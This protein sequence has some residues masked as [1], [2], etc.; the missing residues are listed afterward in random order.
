MRFTEGVWNLREGVT[1]RSAV[2]ANQV[3]SSL[4]N[5]TASSIPA[6]PGADPFVQVVW[7]NQHISGRGDSLNKSLIRVKVSSPAESIFLVEATHWIGKPALNPPRVQLFPAGRPKGE[8]KIEVSTETATV[9]S[10]GGSSKAVLN[11]RP[12]SFAVDFKDA[13]GEIATS[14]GYQ[15]IQWIH[16]KEATPSLSEKEHGT[17][18][19]IDY[20]YRSPASVRQSYMSMAMSLGHHEK[21]YGFGERFGPFI[22]NGQVIESSNDDGGTSSSSGTQPFERRLAGH[23]KEIELTS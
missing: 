17:T 6:K 23:G 16:H 15:A 7:A 4:P 13:H 5:S 8:A 3:S 12:E 11:L 1:V 18:T 9:T 19:S 10:P 14:L 21:V 22:K 20:Y 2:E